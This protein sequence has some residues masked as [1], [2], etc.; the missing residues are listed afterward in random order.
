MLAPFGKDAPTWRVIIGPGTVF[1]PE[2]EG[3]DNYRLQPSAV[4]NV[5]YKSRLF[6]SGGEGFGYDIW[7][8]HDYRIGASA[9]YDLGRKDDVDG[10]NGLPGI[11]PAPQ[12]RVFT[13][14]VLG[15]HYSDYEIPF[16][17]SVD[18][19][20]T[21]R[22]GDGVTGSVSAYF[23]IAG[24]ESER[25]FVFLGGSV[26][27]G[28]A[29]ALGTYFNVTPSQSAA[30][31]LPTYRANSGLRSANVGVSAGWFLSDHILITGTT[32]A[33]WMIGEVRNSPII[34]QEWQYLANITVGYLF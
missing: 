3:S 17:F 15:V 32:G 33:K 6:L 5:R 2:Y 8:S 16:I 10:L 24:S 7:R 21:F 23:P 20:Y 1:E 19:R 25:Y 29:N 11:D 31:G 27:V 34:Q 12:F 18:M 28:D 13:D 9:T 30:T 4:I 26:V 14:Y 22:D